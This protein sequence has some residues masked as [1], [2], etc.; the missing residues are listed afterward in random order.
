MT[1]DTSIRNRRLN[2][3]KK[4]KLP[5]LNLISL[6]DIFTILVFFLLVN[7]SDVQQSSNDLLKLPE[8]RSEK[9][10]ENTLIIQVNKRSIS[11]DGRNIVNVEK[12]SD[13]EIGTIP[14]LL[15]ELKYQ[16]SRK[17]ITEE[18]TD[19]ELKAITIMGDR[20]IPFSLLKKIMATAGEAEY[21]KVSFVVISKSI[22]RK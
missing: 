2:R 20:E 17:R 11:L 6:M 18:S 7:S 4:T 8:A 15:E 14:E 9:P 21:G 19:D 10:V 22:K 5:S 1:S 13:L 16:A 3:S 12:L